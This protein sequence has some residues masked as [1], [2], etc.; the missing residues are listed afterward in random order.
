MSLNCQFFM[1]MLRIDCKL[2]QFVSGSPV[3]K[4]VVQFLNW[5]AR[6]QLYKTKWSRLD[7][8]F[9][10]FES[11]PNGLKAGRMAWKLAE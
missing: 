11:W 3:Y 8:G 5:L 4:S 7:T 10:R 1:Y 2:D 6:F 9:E